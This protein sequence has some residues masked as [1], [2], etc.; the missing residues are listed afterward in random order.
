MMVT[1]LLQGQM[2]LVTT[3]AVGQRI[4]V[5]FPRKDVVMAARA[6][7]SRLFTWKLYWKTPSF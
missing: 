6:R 3:A 7:K 2:M 1:A 4:K 5:H